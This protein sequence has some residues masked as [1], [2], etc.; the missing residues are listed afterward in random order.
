MA[1]P[2]GA[3]HVRRSGWIAASPERVWQEFESFERMRGWYGVGH[4]LKAYEPHVSGT[5]VT[6]AGGGDLLFSGE[7]LLFDP[8]R[9]L[10]FQQ[11]WAGHGW[12]VPPLVTFRLMPVAGGTMV[13]LFHHGFEAASDSPGDDL[14]GFESGW[15]TRHLRR[16]REVIEGAAGAG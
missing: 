10:T 12:K 15:D 9:E 14:N 16:L 8:P 6:D 4:E 11:D 5:V 1:T 3:L 7:V 2:V 13:E